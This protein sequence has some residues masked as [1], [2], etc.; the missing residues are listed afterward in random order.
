MKL[1]QVQVENTN[2]LLQDYQ[3][4]Q[5]AICRFFHF[6]NEQ[7]AFEARLQELKQHP[8]RRKE[9]V[10]VMRQYMQKFATSEKIEQH[11]KELEQDAVAVVGGQQAGLLTGPLY[12][13]NKAISVLL[14]A[15]EQ[16]EQLGV[17]VV[18]I[19][20]VA[21]EDHDLDEINHTFYAAG[22]RLL[23]HT[24]VEEGRVKTMASATKL[25]LDEVKKWIEQLF[26]QFGET[27]YTKELLAYVLEVAQTSH[28]YTD[29]F[30]KLMNDLFKEQG[31]LYLDAAD[32]AM[33]QYEAPYF[34]RL[35]EHAAEI[36][37]VVMKRERDLEEAGYG[38]PIGAT[39]NAAN[40]FYVRDGERY[41]LT[42]HDGYFMNQSANVRFTKEQLMQLVDEEV[43]LSNNVVTR[44]MMQEMVLP[45]LSFVG[46]AG[47]LAYWAT[48]K[49]GFEVLGLRVPI[50]TPRMNFTYVTRETASNLELIGL[51][52]K[53]AIEGGISSK[54]EAFDAKV[55]DREAKEAIE[56]A[57]RLLAE[58][59][60]VIQRHIEEHDLHV[61]RVVKKNLAFHKEQFDFLMK[62][63]EKDVRLK[64][65]VA[66][67]RFEQVEQ[68]LLPM[69]GFQ[70]RV[71]TPFPYLNQ[72]GKLFIRDLFTLS[73]K[74]S[75]LH[76]IIYL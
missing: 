62:Q 26:K 72:Y 76:Q 10:G 36:A 37:T 46:G 64:H 50:F 33:R 44:P 21:G 53:E 67:R 70:E 59:Y 6:K 14:L 5:E 54:K 61:E 35:I 45:V 69:G 63:I 31:L 19:F 47:E 1:E 55:Y 39:E 57:K 51:T 41:L 68:E 2:Q 49:D 66:Y 22:N 30:V 75:K 71:Y 60:E 24:Y 28:T 8:I 16:R 9:L 7:S 11:L 13:V 58:Q 17:P 40:L 32:P 48:L 43:C 34:K 52:A 15:K 27:A 18:P 38:S 29:F 4:Q 23:K 56:R 65:D 25:R 12:S 20:W 42:R 74:T 3:N 73:L